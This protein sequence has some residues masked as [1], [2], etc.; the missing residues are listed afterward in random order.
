MVVGDDQ[1]DAKL[2]AQR[3]LV[4]GTDVPQSTVTISSTPCFLSVSMAMGFSP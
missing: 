4:I 3:G 1:I 2:P